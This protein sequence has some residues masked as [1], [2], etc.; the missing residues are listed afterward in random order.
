[1]QGISIKGVLLSTADVTV[2]GTTEEKEC[3][4]FM[5]ALK[6]LKRFSD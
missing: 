1:M 6:C 4:A 2:F 3:D 5:H